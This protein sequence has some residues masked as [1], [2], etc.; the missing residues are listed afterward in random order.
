MNP[1]LLVDTPPMELPPACHVQTY[2]PELQVARDAP[3][4]RGAWRSRRRMLEHKSAPGSL[5]SHAH[6]C[7][8]KAVLLAEEWPD[9]AVRTKQILLTERQATV[10]HFPEPSRALAV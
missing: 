7:G 2:H 6:C 5:S 3:D 10:S 8:L 4:L 1:S 9:F